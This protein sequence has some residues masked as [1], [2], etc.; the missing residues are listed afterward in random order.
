MKNTLS[1]NTNDR[2]RQQAG[3]ALIITISILGFLVVVVLSLASMLRVST[4]ISDFEVQQ[5]EIRQYAWA[6]AMQGLA[7]LQV[8]LGG[9][10]T[11]SAK[12]EGFSNRP[13]TGI[14]N[15]P[16][17]AGGTQIPTSEFDARDHVTGAWSRSGTSANFQEWLFLPGASEQWKEIVPGVE[18]QLYRA[19][20]TRAINS[21]DTGNILF[22]Y[23]IE[24]EGGKA[25]IRSFMDGYGKYDEE[26]MNPI[27]QWLPHLYQGFTDNTANPQFPERLLNRFRAQIS[28]SQNL[29]ALL[30]DNDDLVWMRNDDGFVNYPDIQKRLDIY[31]RSQ[32]FFLDQDFAANGDRLSFGNEAPFNLSNVEDRK[33]AEIL[34]FQNV[35]VNHQGLLTNP[36]DGGLKWDFSLLAE[37]LAGGSSAPTDAPSTPGWIDPVV[38]WMNSPSYMLTGNQSTD[39]D[40]PSENRRWYNVT[41][42]NNLIIAP[43]LTDFRMQFQVVRFGSDEF[44]L[45]KRFYAQFWNPYTSSLVFPSGSNTLRVEVSSI[46]LE[47]EAERQATPIGNFSLQDDGDLADIFDSLAEDTNLVYELTFD[48]T[49]WRPGRVHHWTWTGDDHLDNAT[50]EEE[51]FS[52]PMLTVPDPGQPAEANEGHTITYSVQSG[53]NFVIS[54]YWGND[55]VQEINVSDVNAGF[56]HSESYGDFET[57]PEGWNDTGFGF[58]VR[59]YEPGFFDT[60]DAT[61]EDRGHWLANFDMR[62]VTVEATEPDPV[63]GNPDSHYIYDPDPRS[64]ISLDGE[65]GP[66]SRLP[67]ALFSRQVSAEGNLPIMDFPL[68]ELPRHAPLS[69]ASLQHVHFDGER[70]N[71]IGNLWGEDTNRNVLFDKYFLSGLSFS[72]AFNNEPEPSEENTG[73]TI[74]DRPLPNARLRIIDK[75]I[76]PLSWLDI[77]N[78]FGVP[79]DRI[80]IEGAFNVNS[81]SVEAWEA[82]LRRGMVENWYYVEYDTDGTLEQEEWTELHNGFMRFPQSAQEVF[83]TGTKPSGS[84]DNFAPRE[85]FRRG[86]RELTD[87]Q[88]RDLAEEIVEGI[89]SYRSSGSAFHS[90]QEF[91]DAGIIGDAIASSGLNS[92]VAVEEMW[93]WANLSDFMTNADDSKEERDNPDSSNYYIDLDYEADN[94][95]EGD[96]W[97]YTPFYLTQADVLSSIDPFL[98]VRSDTYVIRGYAE[99]RYQAAAGSAL[100]GVTASAMVELVV[101]RTYND[102]ILGSENRQFK[103]I[104]VRWIEN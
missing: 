88:I 30:P 12:S 84:L 69:I 51:R 83:Y 76:T 67:R 66:L 65:F 72:T 33:L 3:F 18:V 9:D 47:V 74:Q 19:D 90:I 87:D 46:P 80:V 77:E 103:I 22:T 60:T 96:I 61:I 101:Q 21:A 6:A 35:G 99:Q 11:Y 78:N 53:S 1:K 85:Y 39:A 55:L 8:E 73:L 25:S 43:R 62:D 7:K 2:S 95:A 36:V 89:I 91:V 100:A 41:Y 102:S 59:M 16:Y 13:S 29:S 5:T 37:R 15:A 79:A 82:I 27:V 14:R 49:F 31:D 20:P 71:A 28:A 75:E 54:V 93:D 42:S 94:D 40:I 10:T 17:V 24:D 32:A 45:I 57:I 68:F 26:V 64:S 86:V 50:I 48:E 97:P 70:P 98:T 58:R 38:A 104:G 92:W 63:S 4:S 81:V 34:L 56:N 44:Q 52:L 23:W